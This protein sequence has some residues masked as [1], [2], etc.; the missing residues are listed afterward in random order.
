MVATK[1]RMAFYNYDKLYSYNGV[2]NFLCGARG[3]GKTYGA[4][5]KAVEDFIKNGNQFILVRRYKEELAKTKDSFF[6]DLEANGGFPGYDFRVNGFK[7]EMAPEETRDEK[8]RKWETAG[9]FIPLS[10]AQS[11]KGVSY[12]RVKTIIFDEFII[13]KG[14]TQYLPNEAIVFTNFYSTVDRY[15]D[16]T[17]VFFL[18]NSVSIMNP[19]FIHYDI[20]PDEVGEFHRSHKGFIVAHFADSKNFADDVYKTRFGQFIKDTDYADYAVGSEFS[21]NHDGL[22]QLKNAEATYFYSLETRAG[23]FSVW[24]DWTDKTYYIQARRPKKEHILTL[25]ADQ[26]REDKT[27]VTVSDKL[28]ADMRT[29]F[30]HGRTFFDSP[31]ARNAFTEI[32]RR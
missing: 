13:E 31:L 21:D 3:L 18:A 1:P 12:P 15:Q 8:K 6:A 32:F 7:A 29:A 28:M 30:R 27:Y 2:F 24:I 26:M 14:H 17:K 20:K 5:K 23:T 19:Y 22:L 10:V 25:L 4:K 11:V 16:K 9:Y